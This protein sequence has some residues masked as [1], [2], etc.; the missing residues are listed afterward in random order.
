MKKQIAQIDL[1]P[2]HERHPV[3]HLPIQKSEDSEIAGLQIKSTRWPINALGSNACSEIFR[4]MD[5]WAPT[6]PKESAGSVHQSPK[7]P[8]AFQSQNYQDFGFVHKK[9][10]PGP[11]GKASITG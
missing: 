7:L 1:W 5:P 4:L 6:Q 2:A 3:P 11:L 10:G 9:S 8:I